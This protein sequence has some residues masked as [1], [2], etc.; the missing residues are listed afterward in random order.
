MAKLDVFTGFSPKTK[1][2]PMR[3]PIFIY[4][5]NV[6][7]CAHGDLERHVDHLNQYHLAS[8]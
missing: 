1:T 3:E 5:I 4:D 8:D 6:L 2:A 7:T